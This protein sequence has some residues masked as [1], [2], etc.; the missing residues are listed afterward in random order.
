M[1]PYLT[2]DFQDWLGID[3]QPFSCWWRSPWSW[4]L[5][6]RPAFAF[7]RGWSRSARR[8]TSPNSRWWRFFRRR[9][10]C[11]SWLTTRSS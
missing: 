1:I 9:T 3:L 5:V 2:L 7:R 4:G 6:V 10:W 8:F 11:I